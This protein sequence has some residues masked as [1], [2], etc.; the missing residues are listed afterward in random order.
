MSVFFKAFL[1]WSRK[2]FA[3]IMYDFDQIALVYITHSQFSRHGAKRTAH[4]RDFPA[5]NC[6]VPVL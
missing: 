5:R 2:K 1:A 3:D 6:L 4:S